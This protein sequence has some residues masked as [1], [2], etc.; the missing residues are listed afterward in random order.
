[1][2]YQGIQLDT[3]VFSEFVLILRYQIHSC[4]MALTVSNLGSARGAKRTK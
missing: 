4:C 2:Y 1:M 3:K